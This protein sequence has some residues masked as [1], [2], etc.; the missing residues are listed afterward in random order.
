MHH[1]ILRPTRFIPFSVSEYKREKIEAEATNMAQ[2]LL[3]S[4]APVLAFLRRTAFVILI[5]L[6]SENKNNY[7]E[8]VQVC[9]TPNNDILEEHSAPG[10]HD[11]ELN[12]S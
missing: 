12:P 9:C 10:D 11:T 8:H 3:P 4:Y 6:S 2:F 1:T 5:L 7:R